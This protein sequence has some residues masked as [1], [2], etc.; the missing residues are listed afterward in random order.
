MLFE[1]LAGRHTQDEYRSRIEDA[2]R[3]EDLA[4]VAT[5]LRERPGTLPP[6]TSQQLDAIVRK[7][8][9]PQPGHRYQSATQLLE[10]LQRFA[11]G[12]ET[13]AYQQL[14]AAGR[15][16]RVVARPRAA[17]PGAPTMPVP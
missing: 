13:F 3:G 2:V 10:D 4:T 14:V 5:L 15:A 17:A 7:M 8:L 6:G 9:A 1:M 16:T 12:V 11:A